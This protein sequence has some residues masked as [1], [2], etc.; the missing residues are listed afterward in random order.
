MSSPQETSHSEP[1]VDSDS[2]FYRRLLVDEIV[3]F[4]MRHGLDTK[5]GGIGNILDDAGNVV[6]TDKFL[7]SQG[8]ALWTFSALYNRIAPRR[9]WL[10]F[11]HHIYRYLSTHGR[12]D[13]G[14]W[15]YRL[16]KDGQVLDR[17][18][19][20]SVDGFVM[21]GLSEYFVATRN[22]DALQLA[23]QTYDTIHDR[24]NTRG[25]YGTAPYAIPDGMRV[26]GIA[27]LF[28]YLFWNLGEVAQRDDICAHGF[29][30]GARNSR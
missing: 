23:L 5:Y 29:E 4:W 19:S 16:D 15:M 26:H 14:Y 24:L 6:G 25:S 22:E 10:D 30:A 28:S 8:R 18:I 11:A 3:P 13:R 21:G 12:D 2:Q 7:W 20:I 1:A 27:M 9:E 17:D